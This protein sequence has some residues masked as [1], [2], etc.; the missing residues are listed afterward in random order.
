MDV[1]RQEMSNNR[2]VFESYEQNPYKLVGYQEI[3]RHIIF[4]VKLA[5][6]F[7]R[8]ARFVADE[9]KTEP[10]VSITYSAVV[11]R[12]SVR[13]LL[14]IATLNGLDVMGT[15]IQKCVPFRPEQGESMA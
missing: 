4:G 9:H 14:T 11:S 5:E 6:N 13:T 1:V 10:P 12:D 8:K 15:D 2:V 3:T 7:K